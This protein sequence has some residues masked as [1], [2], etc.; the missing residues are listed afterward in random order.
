MT[1]TGYVVNVKNVRPH[2]NADRLQIATFFTNDVCIGI[3]VPVGE[4]G[5]YFPTDL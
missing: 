3:D 5:I 4:V 1:H 2:P